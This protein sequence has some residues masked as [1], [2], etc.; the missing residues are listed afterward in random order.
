MLAVPVAADKRGQSI[1]EKQF[2]VYRETTSPYDLAIAR[3]G[4]KT[5]S[6]FELCMSGHFFSNLFTEDSAFLVRF[7]DYTS[8]RIPSFD[9]TARMTPAMYGIINE[10][11]NTPYSGHLKGVYLEAKAIELFL[12][13]IGQL[14][15][16]NPGRPSKLSP[17]DLECL[18]WVRDYI[19]LHYDEPCPIIDLARKAGINQMKLKNGFKELFDTTVFG[20]LSDVRMQEAKRLLLDEKM[21]VGE[22]ADR[23]GYKYPHHF[24]AAFRK[25]FGVLPRELLR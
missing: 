24:T 8:D 17:R 10:M 9:F 1:P 20:Y 16:G 21:Y 18:H 13:Q 12:L 4:D 19:D 2:V 15:Q 5:C 25:R 3:T 22:V 23:V 14:D 7:H 6:F 11:Q